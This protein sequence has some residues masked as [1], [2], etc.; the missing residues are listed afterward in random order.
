ME[1][2]FKRGALKSESDG[3]PSRAKLKL[4]ATS[5]NQNIKA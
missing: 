5:D 1:A 3:P 2:L 4:A